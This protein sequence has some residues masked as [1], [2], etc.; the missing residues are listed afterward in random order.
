MY[1]KKTC[2][3][4]PYYLLTSHMAH[5]NVFYIHIEGEGTHENTKR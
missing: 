4:I 5:F 2:V 3:G 1:V